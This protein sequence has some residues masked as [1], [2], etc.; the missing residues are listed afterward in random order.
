MSG[1]KVRLRPEGQSTHFLVEQVAFRVEQALWQHPGIVRSART[2]LVQIGGHERLSV[3][4][5]ALRLL[6]RQGKAK[7]VGAGWTN[8]EAE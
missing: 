6:E 8:T 7:R 1:G 4:D 2:I 3:V 5:R